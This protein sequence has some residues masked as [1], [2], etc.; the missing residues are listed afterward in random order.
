MSWTLILDTRSFAGGH[1]WGSR[2]H[3]PRQPGW[4]GGSWHPEPA[5]PCGPPSDTLDRSLACPV[6]GQV[7]LNTRTFATNSTSG[8]APCLHLTA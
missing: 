8:L 4:G 3:V 6:T 1:V 2:S 7:T 5:G